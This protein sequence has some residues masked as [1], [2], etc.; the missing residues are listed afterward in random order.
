MNTAERIR[1]RPFSN[2]MLC[3]ETRDAIAERMRDVLDG[4]YF[5]LVIGNSYDE[6]SSK[7]SAIEV[8]PSQRL[9]GPIRNYSDESLAGI[10]WTTTRLAMGVH[11]TAQTLAEARDGRQ[12]LYVHFTFD[13]ERITIDHYAP[14]GYRLLWIFAV[15]RHDAEEN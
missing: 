7:F 8:L 2:G 6:Y 1:T 14:A 10:S 4:Q 15:E 13:P 3:A 9:A 11:T 12:H 5:T